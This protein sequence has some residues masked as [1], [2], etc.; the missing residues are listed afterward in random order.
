[1][2]NPLDIYTIDALSKTTGYRIDPVVCMRSTIF[3]TINKLYGG[4]EG[5]QIPSETPIQMPMERS[6]DIPSASSASGQ[7]LVT[8]GTETLYIDPADEAEAAKD[9]YRR[10]V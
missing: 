6:V 1:M 8:N 10:V 3:E 2:T 9:G 7:I 4:W 5:S